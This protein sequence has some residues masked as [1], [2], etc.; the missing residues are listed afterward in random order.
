MVG[1]TYP[2]RGGIAHY[3]TLLCK[4]LSRR[5]EVKLISMKRQYPGLLFPG[6][7][8]LDEESS[9]RLSFPSERIL[10]SLM[11]WSWFRAAR[12]IRE[13]SPDMVVIQW[14]QP[15]LA[16][17]FGVLA[18]LLKRAGLTLTFVCHNVK[19]HESSRIDGI[20]TRFALLPGDFYMV[21][22]EE[23]KENL[24]KLKPGAD[25]TKAFHPTYESFARLKVP[26][27]AEARK[28]L[29]LKGPVLLFFGFIRPYKGLLHLLRAFPLL[30][31]KRTA[32]LLIVGE[33]YEPSRPYLDEIEKLGIEENVV[34][35]D[36]YVPNEEVG[37]YFSACDV[38]VLPYLSAT[39]SGIIQIA[40]GFGKPV[41]A[42][43]VGGIHE[44]VLDGETGKLVPPADEPALYEAMLTLLDEKI[45]VSCEKKIE[46]FRKRFSWEEFVLLIEGLKDR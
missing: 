46:E 26:E 11:P 36:R 32:T 22:S 1:V 12:R 43:A 17:S 21:H 33:F 28:R 19:P 13:F 42:T 16:F 31:E 27:K 37:L 25:V 14:W 8:Q 24:L 7:S 18:R 35:V 39:Q 23:D 20:L 45:R 44:V 6:K 34:I 40:Y 4:E 10:D 5:H 30:L 29:G 2:Y 41:V 38:V 3:T 9:E 15:F